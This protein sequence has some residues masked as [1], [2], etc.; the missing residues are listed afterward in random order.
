LETATEV[1][2]RWGKR[3]FEDRDDK[4]PS[5]QARSRVQEHEPNSNCRMTRERTYH[6]E[7]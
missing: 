5:I 2:G 7:H 4:K 6:R 3:F 1:V